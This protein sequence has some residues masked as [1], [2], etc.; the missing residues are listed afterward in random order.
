MTQ[1]PNILLQRRERKQKIKIYLEKVLPHS[2]KHRDPN[3]PTD[4]NPHLRNCFSQHRHWRKHPDPAP[5]RRTSAYRFKTHIRPERNCDLQQEEELLNKD[6][7]SVHQTNR[8]DL[9]RTKGGRWVRCNVPKNV[10]QVLC[11]DQSHLLGLNK[12]LHLKAYWVVWMIRISP[13]LLGEWNS[14]GLCRY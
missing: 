12:V 2:I 6:N 13:I 4:Q 10:S 11:R 14:Y 9:W 7:K 8:D 1:N 5:H 3:H